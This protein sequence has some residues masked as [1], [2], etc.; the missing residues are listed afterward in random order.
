MLLCACPP[1]AAD[2][3]T[4]TPLRLWLWL[5]ADDVLPD[6]LLDAE[7][8]AFFFNVFEADPPPYGSTPLVFTENAPDPVATS[9]SAFLSVPDIF[10]DP[11]L[12]L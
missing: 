12:W 2:V 11:R 10:I 7:K 9:M 1:P 5:P 8:L 6:Q 4:D 3:V